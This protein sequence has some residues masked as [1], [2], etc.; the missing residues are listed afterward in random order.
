MKNRKL[1]YSAI[2]I[3]ALLICG[4]IWQKDIKDLL[5]YG[6]GDKPTHELT[7]SCDWEKKV[8]SKITLF[9]Q[10][11]TDPSLESPLFENN[12]GTILETKKTEYGYSFRIQLSAKDPSREPLDVVNEWYAKLR[13]EKKQKGEVQ[14]ADEPLQYFHDGRLMWTEDPHPAPHKIRYKIDVKAE[15]MQQIL[16][17][18]SGDPG[19]GE[20]RD[21]ICGSLV[22]TTWGGHPPYFEFDDRSPD[23]YLFIGSY[24]FEGPLIDLNSIRF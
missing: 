11:C 10:D 7:G 6:F 12:D 13:S 14:N 9:E 20:G 4:Y 17:E 2:V 22:G 3:L 18:Y 24:G 1:L 21:Y 15:I 23:K 19:G 8:F 16:H 5:T